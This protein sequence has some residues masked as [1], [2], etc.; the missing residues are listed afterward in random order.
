MLYHLTQALIPYM[1]ALDVFRYHTVRAGGAAITGFLFCILVGP[2][3]IRLLHS[4]KVGQIIKKDHVADL[5][6][7]H[8]GKAG[9][10]TMG[11]TIIILATVLSL[12]IWST[13]N[14]RLLWVA[15]GVLVL[16]G[17]VGFLDDYIKMR[18]KHN[19]GLSAKAKFAG[20]ILTGSMLGLYL[21]FFPITM[22]GGF[23]GPQDIR[24]WQSLTGVLSEAATAP[25]ESPR[26]RIWAEI[27]RRP[28][29]GD[30]PRRRRWPSCPWITARPFWRP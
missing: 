12:L 16:L 5:H 8:K 3:L 21:Y 30:T 14:N 13:L 11:G 27:G 23:V 10:P 4:L 22:S 18:R 9:T 24:N 6:A 28:A 19:D 29:H 7:L 15:L 20:Q 2:M 17:A 25:A 1:S 26:G